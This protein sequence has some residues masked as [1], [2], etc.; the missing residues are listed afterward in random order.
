MSVYTELTHSNIESILS[1]Y[2]LGALQSFAGIAAGIENSNFFINTEQ[3]RFV[4]TVFERLDA[5]ELPY[6]MRLM[7]HLSAKGLSCPDVMQRDD[8]SL[9]FKWTHDGEE[10]CGCIVSC[11]PGVT[12]D[13][14]SESQLQS[15]GK[16]L[17]QLHLAG[18]DFDMQRDN[19]TGTNWLHDMVE[20]LQTRCEQNYGENAALLLRDELAQQKC[21]VWDTLPTG[22]IHGD[23]FVDNIL[24]QGEAV[25]GIID[26]YYAHTAPW[27]MDVA[28]ALNAQAVVLGDD[29]AKRMQVFLE[30]YTSLRALQPEEEASLPMMLRLSAL[31][32]WVSRL[33]DALFPREGAM[34]Q[35]KDPCEY[36]QK[37]RFHQR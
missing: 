15:A 22:V 25:A 29:D 21:Y 10:K 3:G 1:S 35:V 17:A 7:R 37:L 14:L 23:L 32:F 13:F 28:I 5:H 33:Y 24:F 16:A 12:L 8:G 20:K 6:F 4:L 31:R 18:Q 11:L 36:E 34:T 27:V 9:L 30:G 26:F 2:H 19:P